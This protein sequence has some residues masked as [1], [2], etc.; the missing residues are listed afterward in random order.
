MKNL[1][2]YSIIKMNKITF[3]LAILG[4]TSLLSCEN[5][6]IEEP[7]YSVDASKVFSTEERAQLALQGALSQLE[8][9]FWTNQGYHQ[10]ISCAGGFLYRP[11]SGHITEYNNF[12]FKDN[13]AW[14]ENVWNSNYNAIYSLNVIIKY[15][16]DNNP[17]FTTLSL[18]YQKVL[19]TAYFLRGYEY[20]KL[21]RLWG[22]IPMPLAP[23]IGITHTPLSSEATVYTAVINDFEQAKILLPSGSGIPSKYSGP[24]KSAADAFLAK[25]YAT[26]AGWYNMP[27]LWEKAKIHADLAINSKNYMLLPNIATLHSPAGRNSEEAIFEMQA[28]YSS[29]LNNL[30]QAYNPQGLE[31]DIFGGYIRVQPWM[32]TQQLGDNLYSDFTKSTSTGKITSVRDHD[33]RV[34]ITYIDSTLTK[35]D[36][37]SSSIYPRAKWTSGCYFYVAKYLDPNRTSSASIRN[38]KVLRYADILLLRAEIENEITGPANAFKYVNEVLDRARSNGKGTYP[39]SWDI[40]KIPTKEDFRKKIAW[41]RMYELIGEG[42]EFF[43][44]RRRGKD[45]LV[46]EFIS[47]HNNFNDPVLAPAYRT[48]E[49]GDEI[50]HLVI[51]LSESSNNNS[52]D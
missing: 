9:G 10:L 40:T 51:P 18:G 42:H 28:N 2:T 11:G 50:M 13:Q 23:A 52:I 16:E 7:D 39:L 41:E 19:G 37:S 25:V 20:F 27:Q 6:L 46:N 1:Q 35:I 15:F 22:E 5:T 32:W 26:Q 12:I 24:L 33:P 21:V 31:V 34:D 48:K 45:F 43:E 44:A 49:T 17:D 8:D 47:V 4:L 29:N 36:G 38:W 30:S 3:L 14:P